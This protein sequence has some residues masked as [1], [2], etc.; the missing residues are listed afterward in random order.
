MISLGIVLVAV[1]WIILMIWIYG[2]DFMNHVRE[3]G[4]ISAITWPVIFLAIIF[5]SVIMAFIVYHLTGYAVSKESSARVIIASVIYLGICMVITS[6]FKVPLSMTI[7]AYAM[8]VILIPSAFAG[9]HQVTISLIETER[10]LEKQIISASE[11]VLAL[12]PANLFSPKIKTV[13]GI[14]AFSDKNLMF[15][16]HRGGGSKFKRTQNCYSMDRCREC[17]LH[18]RRYG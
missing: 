18:G 10:K 15:L 1:A 8:A 13:G 16:P 6:L 11:E 12:S 14:V 17:V 7:P 9:L 2:S 3:K 4:F 5:I